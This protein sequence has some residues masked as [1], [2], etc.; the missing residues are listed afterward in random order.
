MNNILNLISAITGILCSIAVVVATVVGLVPQF[1]HKAV[2]ATIKMVARH[3][4]ALKAAM[5][6]T[7]LKKDDWFEE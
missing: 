6:T 1:R 7:N 5:P 4:A 2:K 3:N